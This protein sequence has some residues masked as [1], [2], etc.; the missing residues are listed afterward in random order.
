V[1]AGHPS[2][3]WR[4]GRPQ[5][6]ERESDKAGPRAPALVARPSLSVSEC[7][8]FVRHS[9]SL[10]QSLSLSLCFWPLDVPSS[11]GR[12]PSL[13]SHKQQTHTHT[14]TLAHKQ[15]TSSNQRRTS[16]K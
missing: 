11:I 10:S 12:R 4:V 8:H 3:P 14:H 5:G 1:F 2:D 15:P 9:Q 6:R 7:L 16:S 13:A